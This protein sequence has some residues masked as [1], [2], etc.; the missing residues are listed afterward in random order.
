MYLPFNQ[1]AYICF[2]GDGVPPGTAPVAK[3]VLM[4]PDKI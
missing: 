4:T 2:Q 3:L 1:T